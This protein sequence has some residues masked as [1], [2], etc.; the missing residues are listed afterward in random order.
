M[1]D[2]LFTDNSKEEAQVFAGADTEVLVQARNV[3]K[4]YRI[5]NHPQDRLKQMLFARFGKSYGREFWALRDISFELRRGETLGI[6][7]RNGSG[8]ST[9]LQIV[10]GTLPP[11]TGEVEVKGRLAALLELGSG[12]NPEFT[13]RDNVYLNG[14]ILGCSRQQIEDA[15]DEIA[16]FADIGDFID[17][18]VKIYSSGML[19]RLAFAVNVLLDPKILI[20]DEALAVGDIFFQQK[21]YQ[22][23]AKLRR[24]GV[25]ILLV[26]HDL[27]AILQFCQHA[28]VL[29]KGI[30]VFEGEPSDATKMYHM[31]MQEK[32]LPIP[33]KT[34]S[35]AFVHVPSGNPNARGNFFWPESRHFLNIFGRRQVTNG[36]ARCTSVALCDTRGET[37]AVFEQGVVASFFVEYEILEDIE[38]PSSGL[39]IM[40]RTG[41]M[42]YAK[43]S[44]QMENMAQRSVTKGSMLRFR[45]D[46]TLDLGCGEY[47]F[48]VGVI[49]VNAAIF[50]S[51][52]IS[53]SSFM[54]GHQRLCMLSGVGSFS[55]TLR[56]E[57]EGLQI[58]HFGLVDLR[59]Q[60]ASC[61]INTSD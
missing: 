58:T 28:I 12:F 6:I 51:G 21:C 9:L 50:H 29:D 49:S 34:P 43:H 41:M 33:S 60:C 44:L 20:V 37:C 46:V 11:T 31:L 16:A 10:A 18:P 42:V 61:C 26:T 2:Q 38:I 48:D 56:K 5:Y 39:S 45:H 1:S 36:K 59:S 30:M 7:G 23:L 24:N 25:T 52:S 35:A 57:Y 13:G 17:Q 53:Y 22:H 40:D 32:G 47:T 3:G 15:F 14:T 4:V 8:K 54:R 27:S 19:V 55:V